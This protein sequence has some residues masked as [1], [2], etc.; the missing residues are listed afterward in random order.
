MDSITVETSTFTN[1]NNTENNCYPS[2]NPEKQLFVGLYLAVIVLGIPSNIFF[3]F[4]SCQH[5]RQKNELGVYL[6]NLA[7]SD[8]LFIACLPVWLQFM[9]NDQWIHGEA[10]CTV[11]IFLL[12]T[13]FYTSAVLLS[14]I[15]VDRYLAVV[16]PLKFCTFRK[17]KMAVT[18]SVTAWIFT[19]VFNAITVNLDS[20]YDKENQV[21][22]DVHPLPKM[23]MR[24]NIARLIIGFLIPAA[25]VGFC[26]WQICLDVKR[27]RT[28]GST[29]RRRVFKLLGSVL[30]TLYICF[31]PVH[32]IM[33]L[34]G[35]VE[36]CP[37]PNWLLI[38]YK[39]SILLSTLN[40]LADPLLYCFMSRVGQASASNAL[41]ILRKT[42]KRQISQPKEEISGTGKSMVMK[43]FME[44]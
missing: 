43:C 25:V 36:I 8:L 10:A 30:L 13:N 41:H 27:N 4:V 18:V 2:A 38:S 37:H 29:E 28:L 34:K 15:A 26:C 7:L 1:A 31:G 24:V 33:V 35:L 3:L 19:A 44:C 5:I 20:V 6:F 39:L 40:C 16:H 23:Q 9:L 42:C 14:C 32:I 11:C 22:L 21:C 12:F 17:R